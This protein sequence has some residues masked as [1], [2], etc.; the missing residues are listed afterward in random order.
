MDLSSYRLEKVKSDDDWSAFINCS[1]QGTIFSCSEFLQ[2]LDIKYEQWFCYKNNHLRR[3]AALILSSNRGS[4]VEPVFSKI[5]YRSYPQQ[6]GSLS[7]WAC[8][9][10]RHERLNIIE[11]GSHGSL[12]RCRLIVLDHPGLIFL[13]GMT[14]NISTIGFWNTESWVFSMHARS[15]FDRFRSLGII[16]D[17]GEAAASKVNTVWDHIED[18]W[19]DPDIQKSRDLFCQEFART[20]RRWWWQWM[21]ALVQV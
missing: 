9:S 10:K 20:D 14:A 8:F 5:D 4:V 13:A 11:D 18:W 3:A 16:L 19:C 6:K 21:K 17:S 2:S 12:A 1:E 15:N 7:D